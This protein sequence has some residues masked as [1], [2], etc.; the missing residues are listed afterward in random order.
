MIIYKKKYYLRFLN[1]RQKTIKLL[2][3]YEKK[4]GKY[5]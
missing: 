4:L 5:F 2:N 3:N 1:L